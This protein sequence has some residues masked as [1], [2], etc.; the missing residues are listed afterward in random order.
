MLAMTGHTEMRT[1][2]LT[3]EQQ[4]EKVIRTHVLWSLGAGLMPVPLFDI[5]AVTAIQI[6]ML[7]QLASM[8]KVDYSASTG[9]AFVAALTGGTFARIAASAIKAIPG[10]GSLVG[11]LS[12]SVMSGASTYA[13]GQVARNYFAA[14]ADLSKVGIGKAKEAYSQEFERGKQVVSDLEKEKQVATETYKA[15]FEA[16]ASLE[17][18]MEK[19]LVT[20]EEFEALKGKLL[21]RL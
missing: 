4:A 19:G 17:K 1:G 7:R 12:M 18:L 10:V 5:A 15:A 6:D 20:Q 9:K 21:E 3:K 2:T 13:V 11:G 16:I 14:G 8:Y